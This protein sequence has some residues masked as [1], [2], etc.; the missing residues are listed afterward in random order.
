MMSNVPMIRTAK[1]EGESHKEDRATLPQQRASL[2]ELTE[3]E[4]RV[5]AGGGRRNAIVTLQEI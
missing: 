1:D 5:V 4:I 2:V 3:A